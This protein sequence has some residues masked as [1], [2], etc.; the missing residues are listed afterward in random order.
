MFKILNILGGQAETSSYKGYGLGL[1][2]ELLTSLLSGSA[3][4]PHVRN[5]K[6]KKTVANISHTFIAI[7]PNFF[8]PDFEDNLDALASDARNQEPANQN[9]KVKFPGD[10]EL[11]RV[12]LVEELDGIPYFQKQIDFAVSKIN[13]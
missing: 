7:D 3:R 9:Q 10:P 13:L 1:M 2:V 5:W 4:A 8:S 6:D 11:E 12:K